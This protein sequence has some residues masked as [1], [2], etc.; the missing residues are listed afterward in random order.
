MQIDPAAL[1]PLARYQ[2]LIGAVVPRPIAWV[3]TRSAA[4]VSNLAPF[5]FFG[6]FSTAPPT[7]GVAPG[8]RRGEPKDTLRNL[9]DSGECVIA[10]PSAATAERMVQTS[11]DY[12]AAQSEFAAVG[13]GELPAAVV[14]APR[15]ADAAV[16]LECRVTQILP[17]GTA[18][19]LVLAEVVCIHVDDAVLVDGATPESPVI[20]PRRLQAV[21]RLG[22]QWYCHTTALFEIARPAAPPAPA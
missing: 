5:S 11:A 20:D 9:Q 2:L 7:V 22:G 4:G 1:S 15:V 13:V 19:Q 16:N 3:A 10:I 12:A 21:G 6:A 18:S 14:S 8:L 17:I